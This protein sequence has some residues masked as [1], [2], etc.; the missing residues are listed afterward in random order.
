MLAPAIVANFFPCFLEKRYRIR[1]SQ[2]MSV[3]CQHRDCL[4][5]QHECHVDMIPFLVG[6][7]GVD[8]SRPLF[9]IQIYH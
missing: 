1:V 8:V 4:L 2:L 6:F 9:Y 5:I 7:W 3:L